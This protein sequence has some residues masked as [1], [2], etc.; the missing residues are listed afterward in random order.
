MLLEKEGWPQ[1]MM[2]KSL[3][4]SYKIGKR[5]AQRLTSQNINAGLT[6]SVSRFCYASS[7]ELPS[8][9]SCCHYGNC[10]CVLSIASLATDSSCPYYPSTTI[11]YT[12]SSVHGTQ[13][14]LVRSH[15]AGR[16]DTTLSVRQCTRKVTAK[17]CDA[18]SAGTMIVTPLGTYKLECT[19]IV[20][21]RSA[22]RREHHGS[23]CIPTY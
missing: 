3:N 23:I 2:G 5:E 17:T 6:L 15:P 21:S 10:R 12:T 22:L 4:D 14:S 1:V 9:H 20:T 18:Y 13:G 16:S 7:K 11:A 19:D 8:A